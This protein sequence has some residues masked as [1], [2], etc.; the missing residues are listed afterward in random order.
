MDDY[1]KPWDPEEGVV[2]M[3]IMD[4]YSDV[5]SAR[6]TTLRGEQLSVEQQG[7]KGVILTNTSTRPGASNELG[8]LNAN[9][10]QV[11]MV[12]RISALCGELKMKYDEDF[13]WE[14]MG[15]ETIKI[16]VKDPKHATMLA[17]KI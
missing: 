11:D 8:A 2:E 1:I 17:M 10:N 9:Y 4:G 3:G 5:V 12:A 14:G 6:G 7:W 16:R 15:S 13:T